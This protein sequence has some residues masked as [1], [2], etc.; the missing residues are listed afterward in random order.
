MKLKS[1][2]SL[3]A[4]QAEF[5]VLFEQFAKEIPERF[6]AAFRI[7]IERLI[8]GYGGGLGHSLYLLFGESLCCY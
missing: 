3:D 7:H 2:V 8:D 5:Q 6:P 4:A 1:G